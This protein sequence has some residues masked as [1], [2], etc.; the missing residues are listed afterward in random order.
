[1]KRITQQTLVALTAA[2]LLAASAAL[3]GPEASLPPPP[4]AAFSFAPNQ[5]AASAWYR[6]G[7][8]KRA[9]NRHLDESFGQREL[10]PVLMQNLKRNRGSFGIAAAEIGHLKDCAGLLT[11]LKA[12]GIPVSVE[13]PAFTQPLDGAQF[14]RA[15]IQRTWL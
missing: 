4:P 1:V 7:D 14:A 12:E 2:L 5:L 8:P 15:E 9:V 3:A 13:V 6:P 10:W 11:L